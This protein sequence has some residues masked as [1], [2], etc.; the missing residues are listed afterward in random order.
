VA[1]AQGATLIH[2]GRLIDGV[3]EVAK[4]RQTVVVVDGKI[5]AVED[6]YRAPA[7]GDRVIDLT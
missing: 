4:T 7:A 6:G 1:G 5:T 2:A 3:S